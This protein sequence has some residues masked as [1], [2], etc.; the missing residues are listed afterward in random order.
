MARVQLS[1]V[2]NLPDILSSEHFTFNLAEIPGSGDA[3]SLL[4]KCIDCN[5]PGFSTES[6]EAM[7]HGVVRNFRGRK[8]YPRT[9]AVT[10]VE[11]ST[12]DTLNSLRNWMEQIVGTNSNTS[13]GGIADYGV[14]A[15][16]TVY[17]QAGNDIDSIDFINC[18]VQDVPDVQVTGESSTLMRVTA[19]FKYDYVQYRGVSIR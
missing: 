19:T 16:L 14:L 9:L 11:D 18:F 13:I 10:F 15:T 1:E 2:E 6:Y 12:M 5:I 3:Y 8:M 4:L 7:I 17:D